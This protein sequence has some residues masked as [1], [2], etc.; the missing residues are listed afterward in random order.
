[1]MM[2]TGWHHTW[3]PYTIRWWW[4]WQCFNMTMI[5][6]ITRIGFQNDDRRSTIM[7]WRRWWWWWGLANLA[8]WDGP[9]WKTCSWPQ[10]YDCSIHMFQPRRN[11]LFCQATVAFSMNAAWVFMVLPHRR[12]TRLAEKP[13]RLGSVETGVRITFSQRA[14]EC[15][16]SAFMRW[17]GFQF[18]LC[19]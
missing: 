2:R 8:L 5:M 19:D 14:T 3:T 11:Y 1:M 6:M 12:L 7:F 18:G 13:T 16:G 9:I 15:N 17:V 10:Q 4:G